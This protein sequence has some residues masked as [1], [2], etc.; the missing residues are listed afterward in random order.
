MAEWLGKGLQNP[1]QR[2]NSA[3]DLKYFAR[4][5]EL[6]DTRDLKSLDRKIVRVR[7]SPWAPVKNQLVVLLL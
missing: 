7:V 2:F 3:S 4:V 6:V 5:V 1:V